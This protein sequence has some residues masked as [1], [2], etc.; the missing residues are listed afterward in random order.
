M[1][2]SVD[3]RV[4]VTCCRPRP[5]FWIAVRKAFTQRPDAAVLTPQPR[6]RDLDQLFQGLG[7]LTGARILAEIGEEFSRFADARGLRAYVGSAP[8]TRE[9]SW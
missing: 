5:S 8:V 6:R 4:R 1:P 3:P 9:T 7:P 2:A